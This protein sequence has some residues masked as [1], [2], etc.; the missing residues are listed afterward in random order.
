M[1]IAAYDTEIAYAKINLALHVRRRRADGYHDIESVF[2]FAEDGDVL[3]A[4]A[5]CDGILTLAISGPFAAGLDSQ[6]DNLV[7]QAGRALQKHG[8]AGAGADI[9][10]VKNL[11]VAAGIGGGSAD[12]A[13]TL[14]LLARLWS[15]DTDMQHIA[16]ALGSDV[17]ACLPSRTLF[18]TGRGEEIDFREIA[19][20]SGSPL[21]LVNPGKGLSTGPVFA[22]WDRQDR[23]VLAAKNLV[24][25]ASDGRNDLYPSAALL[26]P[27]I[28]DVLR[29]LSVQ[30]GVTLARMSG[31]GA[32]CFALFESV[33]A[34]DAAASALP[35]QWW[36]MA[37]RIRSS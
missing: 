7:L 34:R 25:L 32:T 20:L 5:R 31:S 35:K 10:L 14:R 1:S 4:A 33:V 15:V 9:H 8:P 18:G 28:D 12:A 21:L 23:G 19:G 13:A 17:P 2:A 16:A 27:E 11:P 6:S 24:D 26:V 3:S 22:G 29:C 36:R 37:T 30:P